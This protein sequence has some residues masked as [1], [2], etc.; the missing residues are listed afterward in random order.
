MGEEDLIH[1]RLVP[2]SDVLRDRPVPDATSTWRRE[3][4]RLGDR[5]QQHDPDEDRV[6]VPDQVS[7]ETTPRLDLLLNRKPVVMRW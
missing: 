4:R 6:R 2:V 3:L 7:A 1:A 5:P